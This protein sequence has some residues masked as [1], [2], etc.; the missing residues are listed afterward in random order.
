MWQRHNFEVDRILC[1]GQGRLAT[2]KSIYPDGQ[3]Y[4]AAYIN[5]FANT[6]KGTTP[7]HFVPARGRYRHDSAVMARGGRRI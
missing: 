5:F 2:T 1:Q 3:H 7:A 6:Q 4:V